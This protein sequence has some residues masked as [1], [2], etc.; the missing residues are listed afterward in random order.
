M[1]N[2]RIARHSLCP[3]KHQQTIKLPLFLLLSACLLFPC[4]YY[5]VY[6][7]LGACMHSLFRSNTNKEGNYDDEHIHTHL[8]SFPLFSFLFFLL[9][10][11]DALPILFIHVRLLIDHRPLDLQVLS[12]RTCSII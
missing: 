4:A 1:K 8:Y 9:H 10:H 3:E 2:E 12:N 7:C 5:S 6:R 11:I